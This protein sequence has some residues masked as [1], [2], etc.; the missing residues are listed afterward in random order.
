MSLDSTKEKRG[1]CRSGSF[2]RSG[3][4]HHFKRTKNGTEGFPGWKR[5]KTPHCAAECFPSVFFNWL[6][7]QWKNLK[8]L[9]WTNWPIQSQSPSRFFFSERSIHSKCFLSALYKWICNINSIDLGKFPSGGSGYRDKNYWLKII[10]MPLSTKVLLNHCFRFSLCSSHI[11]Y[12]GKFVV[13][14]IF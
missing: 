3:W 4:H 7:W 2:I 11:E 10:S 9:F 8:R 14:W 6:N 1:C 12:L 13:I 5:W